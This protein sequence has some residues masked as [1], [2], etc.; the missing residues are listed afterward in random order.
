MHVLQR[1]IVLDLRSWTFV[2]AS[3]SFSRRHSEQVG[4][5]IVLYPKVLWYCMGLLVSAAVEI[6]VCLCYKNWWFVFCVLCR[7]V[8]LYHNK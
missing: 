4:I 2:K 1:R 7:F 8:D 5:V 3:R 6:E